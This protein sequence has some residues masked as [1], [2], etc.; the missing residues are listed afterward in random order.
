MLSH[1]VSA[2]A[3]KDA[4][5]N[6]PGPVGVGA[7]QVLGEHL[8]DQAVRGQVVERGEYGGIP[9]QPLHLV[10]SQDDPA[11]RAMLVRES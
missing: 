5:R 4:N 8:Q 1:S 9:A 7:G 3:A 6:L 2:I 10:H 11:A